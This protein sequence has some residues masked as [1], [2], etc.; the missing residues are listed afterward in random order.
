MEGNNDRDNNR[1]NNF[2]MGN[3]MEAG[4]GDKTSGTGNTAMS[5]SLGGGGINDPTRPIADLFP[6]ATVLFADI[7]GFTS[8]SSVREPSQ[9]FVLLETLYGAFDQ[10]AKRRGIFKVETI[11]TSFTNL[12][13][14][15]CF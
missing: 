7:A 13:C 9:V 1:Q 14:C 6:S 10:I 12:V 15:S 5:T 4:T 8:W 3:G 11:G 2:R